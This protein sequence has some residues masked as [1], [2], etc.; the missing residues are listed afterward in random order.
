MS[1]RTHSWRSIHTYQRMTP[2]QLSAALDTLNIGVFEAAQLFG[3]QSKRV[4]EWLSGKSDIPPYVS[5]LCAM[6]TVPGAMAMARKTVDHIR[7][8]GG[9][10]R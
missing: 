9:D 3:S 6:L 7:I 2:E 1:D 5:I 8:K 4:E 10:E